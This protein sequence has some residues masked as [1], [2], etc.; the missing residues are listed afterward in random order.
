APHSPHCPAHLGK[1][2]PHSVQPY[3]RLALAMEVSSGKTAIIAPPP[4]RVSVMQIELVPT[5]AEQRSLIANLYQYY[6]YESSDWEEEEVEAD[7]RFYIHEPHLQRYWNEPQW[8]S[9]LIL[10]DGF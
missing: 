5:T 10:A 4:P 6:A 8:S 9:S 1:V 7:G 3:M 2:A